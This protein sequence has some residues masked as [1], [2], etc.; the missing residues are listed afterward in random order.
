MKILMVPTWY[1]AYDAEII[2]AGIFHYEQS[3]ALLKHA[4]VAVYF[5]YDTTVGKSFYQGMEKGLLTFRRGKRIKFISPILYVWDFVKICKTFKPDIIH[6]HVAAGAGVVATL[7][8]KLFSIPVV[9]TEH[10]PIEMM[11]FDDA[12]F[13]RR[14]STVYKNS[15][16]NICVSKNLCERLQEHLNGIKFS[17]I[18]NGVID[19]VQ[20]QND[21]CKYALDGAVNCCIV[22][23]F[24]SKDIKGYQFLLPAVKE[25][26]DQGEKI[27]LH[28]CG[29][30]EYLDFYKEM[31]H[32]LGISENCVF[33]GN[34]NKEK[35][36]SIMAQ[37]EFC[38]SASLYE[39]AGVSVQEALL[40][41]KPVLVTKSGGANSLVND[42]V[43][44][45]VDKGST[46]ALIHGINKIVT[47]I[48]KYDADVIRGYAIENFEMSKVTEQ[49]MKLY[50]AIVNKQ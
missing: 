8:G 39:S 49:Y 36:Y 19:P 7:L 50:N 33:Y 18:Y 32:E 2:T 34:C 37:M 6:G 14:V 5:P 25:L 1:S 22:G 31:S 41:G 40:L 48:D 45:I 42:E 11:N 43:A 38:I 20:I 23:S 16:A 46:E 47:Q 10:S 17:T 26:L 15:V 29:G 12:S 4:D 21:K 3:V 24:Y 44:V 30:G 13:V 28:I 35:V 27:I 9:I